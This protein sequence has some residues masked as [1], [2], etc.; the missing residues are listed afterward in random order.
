MAAKHGHMTELAMVVR[1]SRQASEMLAERAAQSGRDVAAV[2][3]DLIEEAVASSAPA[4]L[5]YDEWAREFKSWVS[6]HKPS[7]HFVDDS[8]ESIYAGRGE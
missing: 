5:G 6:S 3:A 2:A 8:R 7:G 4:D 1:I